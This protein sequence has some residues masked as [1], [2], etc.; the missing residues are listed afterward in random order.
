MIDIVV[1]R[2]RH[3]GIGP[4]DRTRGGVDKVLDPG[5]PT[6]FEYIDEADEIG[7]DVGMGIDER[8][9][10]SGLGGKIDHGVEAIFIKEG[11]HRLTIGEI[12]VDMDKART[13][14]QSGHAMPL[15]LRIIVVVEVI[16][17]HHL[18]PTVDEPFCQMCSDKAGGAGNQDFF[19][20]WLSDEG[21]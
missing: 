7:I 2:E 12:D 6:A 4:V 1:H 19:H 8:I 21:L 13:F 11:G 9:A 15:Q 5:M 14:S 18:G 16:Q 10:D 17:P 3:L 20:Y